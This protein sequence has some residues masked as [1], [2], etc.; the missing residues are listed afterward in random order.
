MTLATWLVLWGALE[1]SYYPAGWESQYDAVYATGGEFSVQLEAE[2]R[3]FN[4]GGFNVFIG[5]AML[6]AETATSLWNFW[7]TTLDSTIRAGF[8]LGPMEV[9]AEHRCAH[10]VRPWGD[11][12]PTKWEFA[13]D[14]VYLRLETR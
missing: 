3:L 1:V 11:G 9:G 6:V 5:G 7:P 13:H 8:R 12:A 10:P 2:A 4:V 14:R